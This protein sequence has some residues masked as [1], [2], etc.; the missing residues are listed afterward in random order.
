MSGL[1]S[2]WPRRR[3]VHSDC[4]RQATIGDQ[5]VR[6]LRPDA[7][8]VSMTSTDQL[9]Q[10]P[11]RS[12]DYEAEN[13][14]LVALTQQLAASPEG[15]LQKL[16]DTA[17]DLCRA[18][19]AGLSLLEDDD[20]R[21]NFHWRAIAGAWAPHRGG[22]T[23]REFGPC[24]IVLDRNAAQL[25]SHPERD[26]PYFAAVTPGVEDGVL[27]PFYIAG[28]AVGTIWVVA[29]DVTRRFDAEDL[30]VMTN[31]GTFAASAYQTLMTL[32]ATRKAND[33]LRISAATLHRFAS[34]I[35]SSEDA[36]VS[37]DLDGVIVSWNAGAERV[38]GYKAE[39]VVGRA[40]NILIL[41]SDLMKSPSFSNASA[42]VNAS[43]TMKP[44]AGAKTAAAS[45]FRYRCPRSRARMAGSSGRRKLRGIS[46]N[47]S[48]RRRSKACSS[49]K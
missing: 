49:A 23:P 39:E 8:V 10:R 1:Q 42:A 43:T 34:M 19:S 44:F 12:P 30:R 24:G 40:I 32:E 6:A 25:V 5:D 47:A 35:E 31:L 45:M 21:R 15:I 20:Q 26:F 33:E 7:D 38:F 29:H 11:S 36:I 27:I 22:G 37:K 18:G 41:R 9:G 48:A 14:G 4:P 46:R 3:A 16:A 13:R 28:E 17:L 2:Q